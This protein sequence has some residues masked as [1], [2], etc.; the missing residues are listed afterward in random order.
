MNKSEKY[1][2]RYKLHKRPPK[3]P[4][5]ESTTLF[6]RFVVFVLGLGVTPLGVL[7]AGTAFLEKGSPGLFMALLGLLIILSGVYLMFVALFP[8]GKAVNEGFEG[9]GDAIIDRVVE[10]LFHGLIK[11][12]GGLFSRLF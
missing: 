9:A 2:R 6:R 12:I 3:K 4:P 11:L 8:R 1:R 10:G 7:I 5:T